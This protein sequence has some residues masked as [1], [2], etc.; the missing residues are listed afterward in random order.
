[1]TSRDEK[2]YKIRILTKMKTYGVI[3]IVNTAKISESIC[4][5][6]DYYY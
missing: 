6:T 1:M 3:V 5:N 2:Q 4:V